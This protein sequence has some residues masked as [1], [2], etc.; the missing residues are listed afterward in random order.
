[1][2]R[3][4]PAHASLSFVFT[5]ARDALNDSA[6]QRTPCNMSHTFRS[7]KAKSMNSER[8]PEANWGNADAAARIPAAGAI[9]SLLTKIG[10]ARRPGRRALNALPELVGNDAAPASEGGGI[11]KTNKPLVRQIYEHDVPEIID[12]VVDGFDP[13]R[14]RD[15]WNHFFSCLG[16][17][18]APAA[19]PR[20]GY[21]LVL[22]RL[23]V[24]V[25]ILI[26]STIWDDGVAKIRC[27]GSTAYA[28]PEFRCY[29]PL[30]YLRPQKD[31]NVTILNITASPHTHK[32][33][34]ALGFIKYNNGILA[35][36]PLLSR[37]PTETS[38]H[39]V[40]GRV[41][42]D[43]IF[44]PRERELLLEHADFG[45]TSIW[46]IANG[47]AYPFVFRPRKLKFCLPVVQLVYCSSVNDFA[48]FSR[49]IGLY[50][51]R[52][53]YFIALLHYQDSIPGLFGARYGTNRP[54]YFRG[55]DRPRLGDLAY[56]ETSMF[57]I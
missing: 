28:D 27:N 42:P 31:K 11:D 34:E 20:Y 51:A 50:F 12:L 48:R 40:D 18:S 44:D 15:F 14:S 45:C 23:L 38:V 54:L 29:A 2:M 6:R 55:P 8:I 37:A 21:V 56:T 1:M 49:P 53:F 10:V 4:I 25:L 35:A 13:T 19:F 33:V 24:G 43:A 22:D 39:I 46:C 57:G 52:R 26:Y 47:R 5:K 9:R 17:R 36:I 7:E 30:L 32:M 3:L 16:R 41:Q